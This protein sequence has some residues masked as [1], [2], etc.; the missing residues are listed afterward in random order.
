MQRWIRELGPRLTP[1]FGREL[2][3]RAG[4]HF[5]PAIVGRIGHP[6][7]QQLTAIGDT[8]NIASRVEAANKDLRTQ[9]LITEECYAQ[10][11]DELL[12]GD[13]FKTILRGQSRP[14]R[15]FEIVGL[16]APDTAFIAQSQLT[17][18]SLGGEA[19]V[20]SFYRQL[21]AV[22]AIQQLF[23]HTDLPRQHDCHHLVEARQ[24]LEQGLIE[25]A[26]LVALGRRHVVAGRSRRHKADG[27]TPL[28]AAL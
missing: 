5:G 8:V 1:H 19:M 14:Q 4:I 13:D 16:K 10:I 28:D 23:A 11:C 9:F 20:Q 6:A 26:G 27:R 25:P 3:I 18:L 12:V 17:R 15:L 22:P 2:S 7:R 21:F 24:Y